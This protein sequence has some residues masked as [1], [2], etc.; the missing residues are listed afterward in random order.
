MKL[1]LN[2]V[3]AIVNGKK[4]SAANIL[5]DV[6]HKIQKADLVTGLVRA[7]SPNDE[8]GEKLPSEQKNIQYTAMQAIDEVTKTLSTLFDLIHA[9][10]SAN[11]SAKADVVVDEKVLLPGVPVTHL[12]FLSKQLVD[13]TTF[14]EK[15]PVLDPADIWNVDPATGCYRTP[16]NRVN[17]TKK[18]MK[19]HEKAPATEKHPA[20]VEVYTEDVPVGIWSTTKLSGAIPAAKKAEMLARVNKLSDAVKIARE[21][22]NEVSVNVAHISD[23]IFEYVFRV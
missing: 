20:Q 13:L 23:S 9:Q 5:T 10:D 7:Y 11:C 8:C 2:Q 4:T 18:V 21:Q 1:K 3:I 16:E 6:H 19:N 12:L 14:V 15:L 17:R 22:A